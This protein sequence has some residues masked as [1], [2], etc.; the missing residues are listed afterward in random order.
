MQ[1]RRINQRQDVCLDPND[2][3]LIF[4]NKL[5]GLSTIDLIL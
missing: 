1:L 3:T 4:T 2:L 5:N